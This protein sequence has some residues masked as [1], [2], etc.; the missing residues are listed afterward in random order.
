MHINQKYPRIALDEMLRTALCKTFLFYNASQ[1][2][3]EEARKYLTSGVIVTIPR[4]CS[5]FSKAHRLHFATC[6]F[7]LMIFCFCTCMTKAEK[8]CLL[9]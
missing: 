6:V 5:D 4:S 3:S 1:D 7:S 8:I 9:T 2:V